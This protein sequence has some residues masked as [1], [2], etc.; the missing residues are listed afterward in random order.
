MAIIHG[1][2]TFTVGSDA[3]LVDYDSDYA[4]VL[5]SA[6][7]LEVLAASDQVHVTFNSNNQ[8]AE[9]DGVDAPTGDY[10]VTLDIWHEDSSNKEWAWAAVRITATPN[11]YLF[12]LDESTLTVYRYDS[13]SFTSVGS[14]GS[15]GTANQLNTV[16]ITVTNETGPDR[17]EFVIDV[18]S[19]GEFTETDTS[20]SRLAAGLPGLGGYRSPGGVGSMSDNFLIEDLAA[21]GVTVTP[22][23][24]TAVASVVAPGVILG[25]VA[26]TPAEATAVGAVVAPT[27]VLGPVA[28]T[29]AEATAVG[30]VVNPTVL[31][32]VTVSPAEAAA[33]GA[34]VDPTVIL[35]AVTVSPQKPH[36]LEL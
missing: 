27:V 18:D 15:V 4:T 31:A 17:V 19:G 35:G 29:P 1:P 22:A 30:A 28:I 7:R 33:V 23:A 11:F 16:E 2:D 20:G 24:V 9:W 21:G 13:G 34:N 10:K 25:A 3:N 12:E 36:P 32:P 14:Q 26:V 6:G 8:L 5:G